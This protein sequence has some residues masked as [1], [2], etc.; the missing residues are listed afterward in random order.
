MSLPV[1]TTTITVKRLPSDDT[2]DGYDD[3]PARATVAAGLRAHIGS[4]SAR[5]QVT[6]GNRTVA[7]CAL[8]SD[9]FDFEPTDQVIDETT[10]EQF[11]LVWARTRPGLLAH[12]EGRLVQTAGAA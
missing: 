7:T 2:R 5:E 9:P 3:P 1:A 6:T 12:T 11:E 8:T 4:P 10:G